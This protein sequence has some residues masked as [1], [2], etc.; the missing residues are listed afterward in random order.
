MKRSSSE[1]RRRRLLASFGLIALTMLLL[2]VSSGPS[3]AQKSGNAGWRFELAANSSKSS[4]LE[5]I[6]TCAGTHLFA[7]RSKAKYVSFAEPIGSISVAPQSTKLLPMRFDATG[8]KPKTYRDK[9]LVVCLDCKADKTCKQDRNELAIDMTVVEPKIYS[10]CVRAHWDP[11]VPKPGKLP[12]CRVFDVFPNYSQSPCGPQATTIPNDGRPVPKAGG[13]IP[14]T[15]CI[16]QGPKLGSLNNPNVQPPA[17]SWCVSGSYDM[18]SLK[19]GKLPKCKAVVVPN[20]T[21]NP[22]DG[23]A[24]TVPNDGRP[25]PKNGDDLPDRYC[26]QPGPK[27]VINPDIKPGAD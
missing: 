21:Q 3:T 19:P 7:V 10:W 18:S 23:R 4:N 15:Y 25:V 17:S 22:C 1:I 20:F 5:L 11:L 26:L 24:E 6:N 2:I 16:R 12:V 9:V 27:P 8:L 13:T 14:D